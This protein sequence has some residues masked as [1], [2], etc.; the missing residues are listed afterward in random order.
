MPA[1]NP[2]SW[3]VTQATP[4]GDVRTSWELTPEGLRLRSDAP[5]GAD[6]QPLRWDAIAEAATA[7]VDLPAQ[8]GGPDMVSWMPS[9]MEWLLVSRSDGGR[10]LMHPLPASDVR[11][12]IVAALRE[13]LGNRWVG[14][15]LP[16]QSAQKRFRISARGDGLKLAAIIGSAFVL[17]ILLLMATAIVG[18]VLYL[19]ALFASGAWVFRNGLLGLRDALQSANTP[20]TQVSSAAMGLVELAG[21]ATPEQ[22][23]PAG[24]SGCPS[25]WW[26]VGV[27]VW[28]QRRGRGGG[29]WR[30]VMARH[31][32]NGALTL[33]DATGRVPVWLRDADLLLT[34]HTW[35]TG[36]DALP[37]R[38]VA[39][40][41]GTAF[42]WH[43]STRLRVR[44]RRMEAGGS[45]YLLGTLDEAHRLP[46]AGEER[47]IA[48]LR[49]A[50]G[51]GEWRMAVTRATPELLR[52]PVT[53]MIGYLGLLA[54]VGSGGA[55][56]QRLEDSPPPKLAPDAVVVWKGRAGRAFIVS[57][58]LERGAL[59]DLRKR[60]LWWIGGGVALLCY[61]LYELIKLLNGGSP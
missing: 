21:R 47:G 36:K 61:A 55:R 10:S 18:S 24:V 49:R 16:L 5:M 20:T 53:V 43:G 4:L 17:L 42:A 33:E 34:V 44:E 15:Q 39:L 41:D 9:R 28:Y 12:G 2:Q 31:G 26:D 30:Q 32:G 1:A 48:R 35:E 29:H 7:V 40:L 54:G 22:P 56:T 60:S 45:L 11:N 6:S 3:T 19:P 58:Q 8:K 46:A 59:S 14:E 38:G 51:T 13:R 50:M 57:D 23:S 27:D 37:A 25:V 52:P